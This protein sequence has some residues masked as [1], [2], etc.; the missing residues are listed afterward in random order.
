MSVTVPISRG[1]LEL[2]EIDSGNETQ[3]RSFSTVA[4]DGIFNVR[5]IPLSGNERTKACF[6][7]FTIPSREELIR[8]GNALTSKHYINNMTFHVNVSTGGDNFLIYKVKSAYENINFGQASYYSFT[9]EGQ[10]SANKTWTPDHFHAVDSAVLPNAE[11]HL[12]VTAV[13]S[14]VEG[15]YIS[16]T[17]ASSTG[18]K[19]LNISASAVKKYGWTFGSKVTLALYNEDE[20]NIAF[21]VESTAIN[22]I[23][24]NSPPDAATLTTTPAADGV[25]ANLTVGLPNDDSINEYYYVTASSGSQAASGTKRYEQNSLGIKTINTN[26][27]STTWNHGANFYVR[28][29]TENTDYTTTAATAGEEILLFRP[30]VS[31]AV[32]YT[33]SALSSAVPADA[34]N[35]TLGQKVY[36]KVTN[37]AVSTPTGNKFTKI[38]VNWDSGSSDT[39][40]DYSVYEMQDLAPV[41][42]N[43]SNTVISHRYHSGG[44]KTVK[45][46]VEDENGFRSDKANITGE[47]PH[48]KL[49]QPTSVLSTSSTR[50]TQAK[51]GDRTTAVTLSAQ[52]SL[53]SGSGTTLE[54]YGWGYTA[55][56]ANTIVTSNALEN[57]NSV[58]DDSTKRVKIGALSAVDMG[59]TVFKIFGL[60]SFRSNGVSVGDNDTTNFDH[61]AYTSATASPGSFDID[62][63]PNIGNAAVDSGG[64]EIH[65]KEIECVVCITKDGSENGQQYDASRFILVTHESDTTGS[66]NSPINTNLRYGSNVAATL[67]DSLD[68][69]D[70]ALDVGEILLDR[71]ASNVAK[72]DV[73]RVNNEDMLVHH[74][75]GLTIRLR[76]GYN[77][78]ADIA[79]DTGADIHRYNLGARYKWGGLGFVRGGAGTYVDFLSSNGI[80]IAST[81]VL[82]SSSD[83][84]CWMD[85]GFYVGDIVKAAALTGDNGTFESPKY[86]KIASFTASGNYYPVINI[87]TDPAN[88]SVEERTY[89]ST[90][91]TADTDETGVDVVLYDAYKKPSIT[92]AI[93][94]SDGNDDTVTFY[95]GV[96]DS[97]QR[98]FTSNTS[99]NYSTTPAA[100]GKGVGLF[101]Y[102][103]ES[104]QEVR[105]VSP[106][107]LDLDTLADA[108]NIAIEKVTLSRSG[109]ISAQM[110]LG[111][112][113]YPVG[114]SRTKLGIPKVTLQAKALDQTGYRA[115]FSLV[116]GNRYDYAFLDSKKL[117]SPTTSYRSLRMRVESGNITKDTA[118][119]NVYNASITFIVLGEEVS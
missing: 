41:L 22:L 1:D 116:E 105:A 16:V 33:D 106:N 50:V 9:Q 85:N 118:D 119:P 101:G 53:S 36:L 39:D 65:F 42:N 63:R 108:K 18:P 109:G 54:G 79:H 43:G 47:M 100:G 38:R 107:T 69:T 29:F 34:E 30:Q 72:G 84:L 26:E 37:A 92:A 76:R 68:N 56:A 94:N 5:S 78:T 6:F 61:Y 2:V 10:A 88:L 112:R 71:N 67:T 103:S 95:C 62:A 96:F 20:D 31:T 70:E 91:T 24:Y 93:Y 27:L 55:V 46:Q 75:S 98:L 59:D 32:L 77:N 21:S 81:N 57:D 104:T 28:V 44:E 60:A 7:Q 19:S 86:Y 15:D 87:E 74:E 115:L 114:V 45:V 51:Y 111:I 58:F 40:E 90:S 35:I 12:G 117:D 52:Q 99:N 17:G 25:S 23:C 82:H 80:S 64:N 11:A 113:R 110:P 97:E 49:G 8:A 73:I 48:P 13:K 3:C 102:W 89:V 66:V 4:V 14:P 83:Q